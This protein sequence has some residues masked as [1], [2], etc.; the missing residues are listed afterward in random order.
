MNTMEAW[1]AA[2]CAELALDPGEVDRDLILAMTKDV[3]HGVARP[4]APLTA[5]IAGLAVGRGAD[6]RTTMDRITARAKEWDEPP[7]EG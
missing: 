4:A 2:V 3:A 6:P 1:T 5:F 7:A